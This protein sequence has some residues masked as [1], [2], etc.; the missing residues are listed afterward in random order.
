MAIWDESDVPLPETL[1]RWLRK[2]YQCS[3]GDRFND[4]YLWDD[5]GYIQDHCSYIGHT[6][7]PNHPDD[8]IVDLNGPPVPLPD[9]VTF[10]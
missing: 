1:P 7:S 10:T 4:W 2:C 5:A 6:V 3:A 9:F 8:I